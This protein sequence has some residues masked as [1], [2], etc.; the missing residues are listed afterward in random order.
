MRAGP[1]Q[2]EFHQEI[3]QAKQVG[4]ATNLKEFCPTPIDFSLNLFN[5]IKIALT[6]IHKSHT[7]KIN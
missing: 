7:F 4:V 3:L 6:L 5:L 1:Q 2:R